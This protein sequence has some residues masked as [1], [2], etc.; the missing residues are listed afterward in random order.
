[1]AHDFVVVGGGI[2]GLT[3]AALLAARGLNVCV[4][5]RSSEVGGCARRVKYSDFDFE[6]GMGLHPC[7]GTGE[8]Y[9]KI[10]AQLPISTP[11]THQLD[12]DY[13]VRLPDSTD[14]H[15]RKNSAE[16]SEE[17]R[18]SFPECSA[19][20]IEFYELIG[21]A[22]TVAT[23]LIE[24]ARNT[25][26]RFVRF[27]DA[28][29]RAFIQTP[30][31]HCTFRAA[32]DALSLPRQK[33]YSIVGGAATLC[34][35][36]AEAVKLAGGSVRLNSPV[37]RLAY[38]ETGDAVGIDLLSGER[39]FATRG[40]ISNMTI[41]DTY[42]KLIGLNRTP[43]EVKKSLAKVRS[44]GAYLIYASLEQSALQR[45]P[46]ERFLICS[47]TAGETLETSDIT[48]ATSLVTDQNDK[49]PVTLKA[50]CPVDDWFAF[51]S[52][53]ED[54]EA[55]D[56]E[57]LEKLWVRVHQAIPELGSDIEVI[58]TANPRTFYD[59]T[60]RKLGMVMGLEQTA[61]S[62][63]VA[64]CRTSLPNVFIIS[65]TVSDGFGLASVSQTAFSLAT[66]IMDRFS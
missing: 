27:L 41:W 37:L 25:S 44:G 28:Q 7:W 22:P 60:R 52:S 13:V 56:Q 48:F 3:V 12:S 16:F 65:D 24:H 23:T 55:W 32:V 33:L 17:L 40:I 57:A 51:Q 64:G 15:L 9:D 47:A 31:E 45:V 2:G 54:Y 46:A 26:G 42:G 29:L 62:S 8:I 43:R 50:N 63:A 61:A 10:F 36:L 30:I 58:E 1:M 66:N 38:S 21:G 11:E 5:E 18:Q 59:D 34:E 53:E 49:R 20:A 6:P 14:V 39:V 19:E 35:L 4:F